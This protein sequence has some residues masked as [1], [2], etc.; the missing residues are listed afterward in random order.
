MGLFPSNKRTVEW[1]DI[2]S[3][4]QLEDLITSSK[5]NVLLFFKHSTRC[6]ISSFALRR[7]E[8]DWNEDSKAG[9]FFIDTLAHRDVSDALSRLSG[10]SHQSP[11]VLVMK[12]GMVLHHA[13]HEQIDANKIIDL[14][15]KLL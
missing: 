11:Q 4:E 15:N 1:T 7:F 14:L 5:E 10:I 6:P 12:D 3:V 8:G 9:A 2:E 13:S